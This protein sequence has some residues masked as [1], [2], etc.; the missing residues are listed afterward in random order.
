VAP[1][2][3]CLEIRTSFSRSNGVPLPLEPGGQELLRRWLRSCAVSLDVGLPA[4]RFDV[5]PR[6]PEA[7][8]QPYA[9]YGVPTV[10]G[11]KTTLSQC[12]IGLYQRAKSVAM[13]LGKAASISANSSALTGERGQ[14]LLS[15]V[16]LPRFFRGARSTELSGG[17]TPPLVSAICR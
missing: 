7:T 17:K 4:Q 12:G 8:K 16:D 10:T 9:L 3:S 14:F 1:D 13:L 11:Q 2:F 5:R 15:E 6:F